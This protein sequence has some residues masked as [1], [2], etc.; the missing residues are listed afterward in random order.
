MEKE[1]EVER[2][3][4]PGNNR[5]TFVTAPWTFFLSG[6]LGNAAR[7]FL[8][9]FGFLDFRLVVDFTVTCFSRTER[10]F[11]CDED[12]DEDEDDEA[13]EGMVVSK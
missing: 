7:V 8:S 11:E 5:G 9:G 6:I 2:E 13:E 10:P 1:K 4:I 3:A 12:E